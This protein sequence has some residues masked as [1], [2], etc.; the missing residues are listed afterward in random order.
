MQ[1]GRFCWYDE[2][3]IHK[4]LSHEKNLINQDSLMLKGN[5]IITF[6]EVDRNLLR[7]YPEEKRPQVYN[8]GAPDQK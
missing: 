8:V 7:E 6:Q 3:W 5:Q 4:L 1:I 2:D